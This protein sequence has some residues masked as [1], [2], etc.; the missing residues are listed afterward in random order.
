M[1]LSTML[2]LTMVLIISIDAFTVSC[3][4]A[5]LDEGDVTG[6]V[7]SRLRWPY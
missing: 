6:R 2:V 7:S 3:L 1:L 4:T 5:N